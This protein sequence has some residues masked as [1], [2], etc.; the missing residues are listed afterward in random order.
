M[1]VLGKVIKFVKNKSFLVGV[2][3]LAAGAVMAT[4]DTRK[5][6][7]ETVITAE[8]VVFEPEEESKDNEDETMVINDNFEEIEE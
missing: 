5:K 6:D 2:I 8:E 3:G 1:N 4:I 7:N